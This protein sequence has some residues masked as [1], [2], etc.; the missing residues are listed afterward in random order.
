MYNLK[1]YYLKEKQLLL[2]VVENE[3][4]TV[5]YNDNKWDFLN[6]SFEE[7]KKDNKTEDITLAEVAIITFGKYPNELL[8]NH[9]YPIYEE[10][11]IVITDH[12]NH[13]LEQFK[14][15]AIDDYDKLFHNK[16]KTLIYS[17]KELDIH[18][19]NCGYVSMLDEYYFEFLKRKEN[20]EFQ[21][22]DIKKIEDD[23]IIKFNF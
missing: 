19:E 15:F 11:S 5:F 3:N 4:I 16:E 23:Y 18:Y 8:N 17:A 7:L 12:L 1:Y 10:E 6:L 22:V 13:F 14:S 9:G 21:Y 20:N 2:A